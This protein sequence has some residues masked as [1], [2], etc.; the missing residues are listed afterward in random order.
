MF[1]RDTRD[2]FL[3]SFIQLRLGRVLALL[4]VT[5][6]YVHGA[7]Y[8]YLKEVVGAL[9]LLLACFSSEYLARVKQKKVV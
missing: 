7:L 8:G 1:L 6:D 5:M 4:V 3:R 9:N 2:L